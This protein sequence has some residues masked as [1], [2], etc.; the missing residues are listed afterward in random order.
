MKLAALALPA[1]PAPLA[2]VP[3]A[4][5]VQQ[6]EA[7]ARRRGA[8]TSIEAFNAVAGDSDQFRVAFRSLGVG[9]GPIRQQSEVQVALGTR[10]MMDLEP[11]HLLRDVFGRGQQRRHGDERAQRFGNAVAKL[12]A[13]QA[14]PRER[15][16]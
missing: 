2:F 7:R 9:V 14:A 8:V 5:A 4:P 11:L 12:Q 13:R 15:K 16:A 3:N 1:D 10:Q 6:E